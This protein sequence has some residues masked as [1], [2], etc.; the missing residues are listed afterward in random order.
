VRHDYDLRRSY[1]RATGAKDF[2]RE[3]PNVKRGADVKPCAV[4]SASSIAAAASV[5]RPADAIKGREVPLLCAVET[6]QP[7]P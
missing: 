1:E 5:R 2:A 3:C 4:R 7:N 6:V